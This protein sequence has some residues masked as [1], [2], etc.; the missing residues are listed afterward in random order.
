MELSCS[1]RL[2]EHCLPQDCGRHLWSSLAL[3][4][5]LNAFCLKSEE[6]WSSVAQAAC[7]NT[8]ART[9]CGMQA[10]CSIANQM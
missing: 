3:A 1:G 5:S 8:V 2:S 10:E 4:A 9:L 7:L 6:G